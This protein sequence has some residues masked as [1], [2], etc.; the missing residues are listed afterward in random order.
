MNIY[1]LHGIITDFSNDLMT[2]YHYLSKDKFVDFLNMFPAKFADWQGEYTNNNVLTVDDSTNAGAQACL[3]ARALG[4]HVIFFVNPHQIINQTTY[5][6]SRLN[7]IIDLRTTDS[8]TLNQS[9]FDLIDFNQLIA[10]RRVLKKLMFQLA[11]SSIDSFL[12]EIANKLSS[13]S[14]TIPEHLKIIDVSQL[15]LLKVCGVRIESHGWSHDN[16]ANF[17]DQE[18]IN[19]LSQTKLWLWKEL[20]VRSTLYAVPFGR[21]KVPTSANSCFDD[22]FLSDFSL[23]PGRV[24]G[25]T[26]NRINVNDFLSPNKI[27]SS[28]HNRQVLDQHIPVT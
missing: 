2:H 27:H 7:S 21:H 17:S 6:F 3:L 8:V 14:D 1:N 28:L 13:I 25:K 19:D 24:S 5:N 10:F 18:V 4:H 22:C 26:W 16:I 12:E 23:P 20:G 15:H 11:P 9:T